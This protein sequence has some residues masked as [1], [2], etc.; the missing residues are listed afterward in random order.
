VLV[1]VLLQQHTFHQMVVSEWNVC[2]EA[3]LQDG[4]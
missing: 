3:L 4:N 1:K 2:N